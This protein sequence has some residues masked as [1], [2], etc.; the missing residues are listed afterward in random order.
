MGQFDKL[1]QQN[2]ESLTEAKKAINE[3]HRIDAVKEQHIEKLKNP[4]LFNSV[5]E[6]IDEEFEKATKLKSYDVGFL[7]LATAL[8]CTRIFLVN[9][10]TK[11]E[12]AGSGNK[13]EDFLHK[14]QEKIFEN[15]AQNAIDEKA[16]LYYAP[17]KQIVTTIGVPYDA[18]AYEDHNY[19][20]FK[21]LHSGAH[22]YVTLGH[23][24]I[25]GLVFGTANI[26]T[27]TITWTNKPIVATNH[28]VYN[29]NFKSPKISTYAGNI[30]TLTSAA[31]RLDED[32][33]SVVAALIKQIIHIGTDLYTPRGIQLPFSNLVL[34][35][36][37]VENLADKI[38]TGDIL[39]IG[40][41]AKIA[42]LINFLIGAVH[43]LTFNEERD[44][45][46]D[47]L[48][49][50]SRKIILLSNTIAQSSNVIWVGAN[51]ALGNEGALKQLDIGGLIVLV[52]RLL[53]DTV[54]IQNVKYEYI[55]SSWKNTVAG[56]LDM[57][58][59]E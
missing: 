56:S 54:F 10:I 17:F 36:E 32:K 21:G 12:K 3:I 53:E 48:S 58:D 8:Q 9:Y 13:N 45:S 51:M 4:E 16:L 33:K 41:S 47:L 15:G 44:G 50:R 55:R 22:R 14:L 39:K 2:N 29:S 31:E 26:L 49:V 7:L 5:F 6:S 52:H 20:I 25:V 59:E 23:D 11:I 35:R 46:L 57:F 42:E 38:T 34:S 27:N 40:V 30:H 24:P 19:H 1:K 28:V 18:N 43:M 37:N